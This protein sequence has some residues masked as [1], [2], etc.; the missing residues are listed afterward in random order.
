MAAGSQTVQQQALRDF[1]QAMSNFFAGTHRRPTWRKAGRHEGFRIV[2]QRG[3]HW[4]VRRLSRKVG[5]VKIPK[6]GWVRFRWSRQIPD[7][8]KSFRV[9]R[10][11]AA[12]WHAGFAAI[13]PPVNGPGTGAVVG[14]DRGVAVSAALSTG[15]LLSV[16]GL[17]A[18]EAKRLLRL[19]RKLA[20]AKRG[21]N[22]LEQ[23]A[24]GRV[25]RVDPAYTS[26]TCNLCGYRD[27]RNRQS[28]AVFRCRVCGHVDHAGVNA[29]KNIAVGRTVTA[30]GGR[31]MGG[32]VNREP[33]P[34]TSSG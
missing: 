25:E 20:R 13:P 10:D 24:S 2:G 5:E 26:Q 32:P 29:A 23:K 31:P 27:P 14:V 17:R 16:P 3:S 19:Q 6:V 33:Q 4:D 11:R 8:V 9:T 15:E 28:Q 34:V 18:A 30:R 12:R 22:R 1:A 21:S 7:Q